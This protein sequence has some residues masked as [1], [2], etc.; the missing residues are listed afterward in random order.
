MV[1]QLRKELI[2]FLE[3]LDGDELEEYIEGNISADSLVDEYL[4]PANEDS[5]D[6]TNE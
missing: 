3:S 2:D 5:R 6:D 1:E 4:I